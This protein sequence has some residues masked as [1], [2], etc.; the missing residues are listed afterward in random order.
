MCGDS[1]KYSHD[2]EH[3]KRHSSGGKDASAIYILGGKADR[4]CN[5]GY[6]VPKIE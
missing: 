2:P 1:N 3:F 6:C 5:G 4:V